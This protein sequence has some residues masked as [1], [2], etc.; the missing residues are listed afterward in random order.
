L[1]RLI[2]LPAE[3]YCFERLDEE[4]S[5]PL[6]ILLRICQTLPHV[7]FASSL[8]LL[9]IFCAR[10]S[11]AA[12]PPLS[13]N[14]SDESDE[15][16]ATATLEVNLRNSIDEENEEESPNV[17]KQ[18][19]VNR[20]KK[21]RITSTIYNSISRFLRTVLASKQTFP[22]WNFAVLTSYSAIFVMLSTKN[23][24]PVS[25]TEIYLWML[26]TGIYAFLLVAL[27]YVGALLLKALSPGLKRRKD[28]NALALRL[29]GTC[30]LLAWIFVER[31]VSFAVAAHTASVYND[32]NSSGERKL[33]SYRRDALD[34][35][36]SELLPVL[37]LLFIMHRRRRGEL[38]SDVLIINSLINSVFSS[39]LSVEEEHVDAEVGGEG[40]ALGTRRFQSYGGSGNNS[41]PPGSNARSAAAGGGIGRVSSSSGIPRHSRP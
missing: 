10:V 29:L 14:L 22:L 38:P 19:Q 36:L 9:V 18:T 12:L 1:A 13:P 26:L 34:Y 30:A 33:Y 2:L 17:R 37:C 16:E 15:D 25:Q 6:R 5:I 24:I 3:F 32:S 20:K 4:N 40:G 7:A 21:V 28:S 23:G 11:F 39:V 8:G 31:I 27:F 41:F 35:G